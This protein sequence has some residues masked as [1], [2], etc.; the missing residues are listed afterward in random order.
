MSTV[1]A[2]A[3]PLNCYWIARHSEGRI[4]EHAYAVCQRQRHQD[5]IVSEADCARCPFWQEHG[6]IASAADEPAPWARLTQSF[7]G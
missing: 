6:E 4:G 5:R 2:A 3:S 7:T 1:C